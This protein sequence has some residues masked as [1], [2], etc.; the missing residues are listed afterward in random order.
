M[1]RRNAMHIITIPH[2]EFTNHA[3]HDNTISNNTA[4]LPPTNVTYAYIAQHQSTNCDDMVSFC[5]NA[6]YDGNKLHHTV[7]IVDLIIELYVWLLCHSINRSIA[8]VCVQQ[9]RLCVT[10]GEWP[11]SVIHN[12]CSVA[13]QTC[14]MDNWI[15]SVTCK[16]YAWSYNHMHEN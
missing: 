13:R 8:G 11:M 12:T 5:Q 14:S 3:T 1:T 2:D 7:I 15:C 16:T 4:H 10:Y 6:I 9:K